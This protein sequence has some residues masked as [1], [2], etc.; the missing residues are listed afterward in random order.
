MDGSAVVAKIHFLS[1]QH[2]EAWLRGHP[3]GQKI[4]GGLV[5]DKCQR[6]MARKAALI[7]LHSDGWVECYAD[8]V[9]L[10]VVTK[11]HATTPEAGVLAAE[12]MEDQLPERYR[13]IYWPRKCRAVGLCEKMTVERT[14][15]Y[16]G[17]QECLDELR[18][19]PCPSIK[20]AG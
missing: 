13:A 3:E 17:L 1:V 7:V 16:S 19:V 15:Y 8:D 11:I 12:V 9:D 6:C 10:R 14:A 4:A 18:R 2:L 20:S 5:V